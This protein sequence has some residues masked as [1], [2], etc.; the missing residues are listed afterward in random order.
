MMDIVI[1]QSHVVSE[2]RPPNQAL[3]HVAASCQL[4]RFQRVDKLAACRYVLAVR[5]AHCKNG[6]SDAS[7]RGLIG[8]FDVRRKF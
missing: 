2:K 4:A 5:A 1:A 8:D 7:A 6:Q 3:E